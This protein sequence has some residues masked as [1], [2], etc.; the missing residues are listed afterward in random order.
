MS[1]VLPMKF[2]RDWGPALAWAALMFYFSTDALSSEH[3]A[4]VI[5]PLLAWLFP[6]AKPETL[7]AAHFFIRKSA[8]FWEYFLLSL[9]VLRGIRAGRP[10]WRWTWALMAL[11]V[12]AGYAALDELHQ[13][14][15]P[16]RGPSMYDVLLDSAGAGVAQVVAA[17]W[18]RRPVGPEKRTPV[19]QNRTGA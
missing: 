16:S 14:F 10:G 8:H 12:A 7:D 19:L 17:L 1:F 9:L 5:L 13:A 18:A 4:G 2:L 11:A 6:H 15:V 3:T